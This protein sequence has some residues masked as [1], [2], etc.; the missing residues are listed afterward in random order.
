MQGF[1]QI[2]YVPYE[3]YY[4][5]YEERQFVQNVMVPVQRSVTDYYAVEHV[6]DYVPQEIEETIIEM[7]PEER[8]TNKLVYVPI[9]T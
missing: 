5:D 1:S 2:E 9:E 3:S 6:I 4:I 8:S 7:V